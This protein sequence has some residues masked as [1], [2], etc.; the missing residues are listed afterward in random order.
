MSTAL[1][2][3]CATAPTESAGLA[4]TRWIITRVDGAAPAAP[5][6]ASL[7]FEDE[8]LSA[9]VGCNGIGGDYR[10]E[11]NRLIAGPLMATRM[12]CEGPVWQ[13]EEAVNALLSAAP[14]MRRSGSTLRLVS[15]GHA[16]DLELSEG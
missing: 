7:K 16:L 9:N 1:L 5:S 6:R 10:V 8:R 14:E 4:G 3:G 2:A 11:G 15:G 13:Q 12:F